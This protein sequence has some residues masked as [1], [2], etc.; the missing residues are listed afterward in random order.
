MGT[1]HLGPPPWL[2]RLAAAELGITR[3]VEV[4]SV[5]RG[6]TDLLA[7][8]FTRCD[9]VGE[10]VQ[11]RDSEQARTGATVDTHA[12]APRDVLPALC[13]ALTEPTFFWMHG[14]YGGGEAGG[15]CP[16]LDELA[17]IGRTPALDRSVVAIDDARLFGFP[18]HLDPMSAYLPRLVDVLRALEDM[19]LR[20]YVMDDV[21]VGFPP[22]RDADVRF[23]TRDP[24]L[25]Q[26]EH[27]AGRW[28]S[29]MSGATGTAAPEPPPV[30][31][32]Q[33]W[34]ARLVRRSMGR[35]VLVVLRGGVGNHLFQCAAALSI[36]GSDDVRF[37]RR[38]PIF[39]ITA[40]DVAPGLIRQAGRFSTTVCDLMEEQ[41]SGALTRGPR[42]VLRSVLAQLNVAAVRNHGGLA[43]SFST[44][45][46][47]LPRPLVLDGA[48][49]HPSWYAPGDAAVVDA[50]LAHVP[51]GWRDLWDG[52][53][54]TVISHRRGDYA[55]LGWVLDDG[56][57][58]RCL[59]LIDRTKPVLV[60]GDDPDHTR[61]QSQ[62]LRED[63]F[64][65]LAAPRLVDDKVLNDFWLLA[66]A[67][68]MVMSNSTFCWWA[69]RVGDRFHEMAGRPRTVL[70][71]AGW[72]DGAGRVVLQPAWVPVP[73]HPCA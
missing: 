14:H 3:V 37:V 16:L 38:P 5:V 58:R 1:Y 27:L 19:G 12:G 32:M 17:A 66:R 49:Q 15:S 57:Y 65:V 45:P 69:T 54:V 24:S 2:L 42:R 46:T 50:L 22:D 61:E 41:A 62:R 34:I 63:G 8:T 40:N 73:S 39:P 51:A 6:D 56:Y 4:F 11:P 53:E 68:H 20:T 21:I 30:P 52:S 43:L 18:H 23:V 59:E 31:R 28:N 25:R 35:Q 33:R 36:A 70:A 48:F 10:L 71:P 67:D 44:K 7:S 55:P 13:A 64:E 29:L 72:L 9:V 60:V 47:D 26:R